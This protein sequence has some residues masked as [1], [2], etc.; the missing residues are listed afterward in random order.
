MFVMQTFSFIDC[1]KTCIVKK[2]RQYLIKNIKNKNKMWMLTLMMLMGNLANTKWCKK[3][4]KMTETLTHG[5]SSESTQR[6]LSYKYQ[7]DRFWMVFKNLCILLLWKKVAPALEGLTK[8]QNYLI[9]I[10]FFAV[11]GGHQGLYYI[12]VQ[13]IQLLRVDAVIEQSAGGASQYVMLRGKIWLLHQ[14]PVTTVL[15]YKATNNTTSQGFIMRLVLSSKKIKLINQNVW[16]L[17]W[18]IGLIYGYSQNS[19]EE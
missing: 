8:W 19:G 6:E 16:L 3:S 1:R 13:L 12:V 9:L 15:L 14:H 2:P 7:Q 18:L 5:Y 4:K 17:W 10:S 11:G